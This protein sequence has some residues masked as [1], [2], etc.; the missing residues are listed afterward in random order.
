MRTGGMKPTRLDRAWIAARIPHQ[1]SMCLLDSVLEYDAQH[2]RCTAVSH[3]S[4]DNPLRSHGRLAAACGIEYAAQAMAVHGALLSA[5]D[6]APRPGYLASVRNTVLHV[7][8][9][10][11]IDAALTVEATRVTGDSATVLYDFSLLAE[12][13]LLLEGRAAIVLNAGAAAAAS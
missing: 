2:V 4:P 11:D 9:L 10:D 6:A 1:G 7:G 3:C 8:R 12:G 5:A 13:R